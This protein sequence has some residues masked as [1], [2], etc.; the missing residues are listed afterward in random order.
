MWSLG[1]NNCPF[2]LRLPPLPLGLGNPT[3]GLQIKALGAAG[4]DKRGSPWHH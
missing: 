4:W 1:V 2:S 3:P